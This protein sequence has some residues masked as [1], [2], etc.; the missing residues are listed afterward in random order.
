MII[1]IKHILT[2]CQMMT[3]ITEKMLKF[4]SMIKNH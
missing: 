3:N 4:K 2:H 1:A